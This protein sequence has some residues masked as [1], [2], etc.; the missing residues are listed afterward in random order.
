METK[1]IFIKPD[2]A[3]VEVRESCYF[4]AIFANI[5][6]RRIKWSVKEAEGGTIDKNGMYTAPNVPGVYE[7]IVESR[8][9]PDIKAS[10]FV[11]VREP[12]SEVE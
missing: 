12:K 4:E 8:A 1:R 9:H 10:T 3:N 2:M 7:I 11:V 6:D 5:A